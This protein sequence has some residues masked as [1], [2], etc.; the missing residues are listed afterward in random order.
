MNK[1]I[2]EGWKKRKLGEVAQL[3]MGQ[4]PTSDTTTITSLESFF[5]GKADF[6]S[7][8]PT[9]KYWCT[10]PTKIAPKGSILLSVRAPVGAVNLEQC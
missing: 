2:P 9:V 1:Q 7:T 3:I 5:Q 8:H 6:G 10:S 4:S